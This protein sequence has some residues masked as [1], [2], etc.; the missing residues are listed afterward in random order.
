MKQKINNSGFTLIE[1]L[2]T[3]VVISLSMIGIMALFE[4]AARGSLQADLN[5]IA[6][7]LAH[8]KLELIVIDKV[9][10]GYAALNQTSYP[11]ETF[12]GSFASYSRSTAITEVSGS[13][14]V[15]VTPNSGYKRVQVTVSWGAGAS[16][17]ITI[18]T[19]LANY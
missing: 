10:N 6:S 17:R 4:N 5:Y 9:R 15:T 19:I 12:T 18:P 2:F 14:M 13:D 8:E 1:L 3:I 11:N 16:K 7:K